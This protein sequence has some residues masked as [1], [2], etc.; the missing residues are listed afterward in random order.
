MEEKENWESYILEEINSMELSENDIK[1]LAKDIRNKVTEAIY[2]KR[3][4]FFQNHDNLLKCIKP[5]VTVVKKDE[6]NLPIVATHQQNAGL[7]QKTTLA[8]NLVIETELYT[9]YV[10]CTI[11]FNTA[12]EQKEE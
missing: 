6:F 8:I 3:K 1:I 7:W 10:Y 11:P 2:E 9:I 5:I 12:I 4:E